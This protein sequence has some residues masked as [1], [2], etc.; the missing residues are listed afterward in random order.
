MS[1]FLFCRFVSNS[2]LPSSI[3]CEC[4]CV[5]VCVCVFFLFLI[6]SAIYFYLFPTILSIFLSSLCSLLLLPA[7]FHLCVSMCF[8]FPDLC[9]CLQFL[10]LS[11]LAPLHSP[12]YDGWPGCSND[13]R[14]VQY[15]WP[16]A[17]HSTCLQLINCY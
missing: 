15:I 14:S 1:N 4:V 6:S 13:V 8:F 11:F 16:P 5:C 12:N 7:C 17:S 3:G 2:L 9:L 10:T